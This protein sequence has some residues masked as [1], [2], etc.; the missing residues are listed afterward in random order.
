MFGSLD[1]CLEMGPQP[2]HHHMKTRTHPG[3]RLKG[4]KDTF[5]RYS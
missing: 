3:S 4:L 2:M 1:I 5:V